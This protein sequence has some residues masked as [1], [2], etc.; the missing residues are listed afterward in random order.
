MLLL[1][2]EKELLSVLFPDEYAFVEGDDGVLAVCKGRCTRAFRPFA[3]RV[4]PYYPRFDEAG[5]LVGI[6]QDIRAK[7]VCPLC[8]ENVRVSPA[9]IRSVRR[10]VTILSADDEIKAELIKTA[11]FLDSLEE[12]AAQ[13]GGQ[14]SQHKRI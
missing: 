7:R 10:A 1:P 8:A 13:L 4:F 2:G 14:Y 9:F 6:R 11:D 5:R 3:C 12:F